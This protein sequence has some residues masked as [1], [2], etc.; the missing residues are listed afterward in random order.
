MLFEYGGLLGF[1]GGPFSLE[2]LRDIALCVFAGVALVLLGF[3]LKGVWG[4]VFALAAGVGFLLY[5]EGM[6]RF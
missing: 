1:S 4:A 3:R 5:H 6:I 2:L